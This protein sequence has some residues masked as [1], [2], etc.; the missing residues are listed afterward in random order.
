MAPSLPAKQLFNG[1]DLDAN[2]R[3]AV[4]TWTI[5]DLFFPDLFFF[6][7]ITCPIYIG[8]IKPIKPMPEARGV[9]R[10]LG[11][12]ACGSPERRWT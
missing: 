9:G 2:G 5:I 8:P 12:L 7:F 10:L 3:L 11:G 4:E 1:L 6:L